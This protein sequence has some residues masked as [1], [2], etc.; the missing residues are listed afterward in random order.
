[1]DPT[2]FPQNWGPRRIATVGRLA[3]DLY[4]Q[5]PGGAAIDGVMYADPTAFAALLEL[6]GPVEADGRT[7]A[8]DNA[9]QFLTKDQYA[10]EGSAQPVTPLIRAALDR[11]TDSQVPGP[12]RLAEVFGPAIEAG[13]LQF[14]TSD[15]VAGGV[16]R[17][18]GLD[19]PLATPA[20]S[21]L[22]GVVNRNDNPSKIDAY[23][24]RTIDYEVSWIPQPGRRRRAWS[25]RCATTL[26]VQGSRRSS[27]ARRSRSRSAPI[28]PS[29][30]CSR[31]SPR[32]VRWS[33]AFRW[34]SVPVRTSAL[35]RHSL[36]VDLPPGGART[37]IVDLE[38]EVPPGPIYRVAWYNQPVP[39]EDISRMIIDPIGA[40]V[41]GGG[42]SASVLVG[43]QR[44]EH[45][46]V[47]VDEQ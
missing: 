39:N 17:R 44:V 25:S 45:L 26:P 10:V 28:A 40:T 37:V 4:P 42:D 3:A 27:T 16:L 12:T 24:Q 38:G 30:R 31:R 35:R 14:V 32:S 6:T 46:T 21:D 18:T 36:V 11:F 29:C 1:M 13:H 8:A 15:T 22:I 19:Q 23:L 9:V 7:L 41:G 20:G 47:G 5:T 33:T 34:A 2:R 43:P